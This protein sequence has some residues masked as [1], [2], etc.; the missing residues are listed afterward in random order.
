MKLTQLEGRAFLKNENE[1]YGLEIGLWTRE[2]K[3]QL[4]RV[5]VYEYIRRVI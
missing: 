3:V 5:I 2:S 1:G 4:G